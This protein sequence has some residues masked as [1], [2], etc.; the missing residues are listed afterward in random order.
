MNEEHGDE[1]KFKITVFNVNKQDTAGKAQ[2][3]ADT[4]RNTGE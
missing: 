1:D 3:K 2:G 4:N